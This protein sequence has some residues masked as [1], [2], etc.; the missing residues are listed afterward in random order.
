[1]SHLILVIEDEPGIVDFLER[2]LRG[3]GFEVI[4]AL[5]GDSGTSMALSEN[6]NLVVLDMLLPGRGGLEVLADVHRVK[7]ELPVIILTALGEESQ[8]VTGLDAGAVGLPGSV[9]PS[10]PLGR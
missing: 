4:A 9:V 2:S 1:V 3:H 7:P 5:D 10:A 6:V 8:R